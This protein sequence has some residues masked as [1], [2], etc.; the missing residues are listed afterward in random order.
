[1]VGGPTEIARLHVASVPGLSILVGSGQKR[2]RKEGWSVLE[3]GW[4]PRRTSQSSSLLPWVPAPLKKTP[5]P[6]LLQAPR[7]QRTRD[8]PLC[9]MLEKLLKKF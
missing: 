7:R 6:L 1:M 4:V 3:I 9:Q 2:A 5:T 8:L